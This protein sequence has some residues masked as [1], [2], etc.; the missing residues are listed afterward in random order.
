MMTT[1]GIMLKYYN[2]DTKTCPSVHDMFL[3]V[4]PDVLKG[5]SEPSIGL[6]LSSW[7]WA[8]RGSKGREERTYDQLHNLA[9]TRPGVTTAADALQ[10]VRDLQI[11][12]MSDPF[13]RYKNFKRTP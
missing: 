1:V 12:M 8:R 4:P 11:V 7:R 13:W 3:K 2:P 6:M 9:L 5:T 10:Y